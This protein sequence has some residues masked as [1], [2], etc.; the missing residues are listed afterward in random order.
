MC[1]H[2]YLY[3]YIHNYHEIFC[4]LL[5]AFSSGGYTILS[6]IY[7]YICSANNSELKL[8]A[9]TITF[10]VHHAVKLWDTWNVHIKVTLSSYECMNLCQLKS[11]RSWLIL[12]TYITFTGELVPDNVPNRYFIEFKG[13][14]VCLPAINTD[15]L[16]T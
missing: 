10:N 16:S 3:I 11:F 6:Y 12:N 1:L 2:I 15:R 14:L 4:Y 9:C 5:Y 7:I 8:I 13:V